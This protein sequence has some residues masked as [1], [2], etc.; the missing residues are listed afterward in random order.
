[1][2]GVVRRIKSGVVGQTT[3]QT[4]AG[5]P[6]PLRPPTP[7]VRTSVVS[8]RQGGTACC[9][10]RLSPP[11]IGKCLLPR[12]STGARPF[13]IPLPALS[14][15]YAMSSFTGRRAKGHR[16]IMRRLKSGRPVLQVLHHQNPLPPYTDSLLPRM[17]SGRR[18]VNE[19][20]HIFCKDAETG[21]RKTPALCSHKKRVS[22]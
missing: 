21:N 3:R 22:F 5:A 10:S 9:G 12:A 2:G 20:I 7:S 19:D 1:M 16:R 8:V 18:P 17:W 6:M 11:V 4:T 15:V 13:P 14:I